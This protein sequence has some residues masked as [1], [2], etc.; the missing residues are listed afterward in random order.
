VR[1]LLAEEKALMVADLASQGTFQ[2]WTFTA[3]AALGQVGERR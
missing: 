3:Q 2:L 1:Q